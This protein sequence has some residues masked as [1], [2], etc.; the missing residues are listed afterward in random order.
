MKKVRAVLLL[1]IVLIF[2]YWLLPPVFEASN[3]RG[4]D[5]FLVITI[6]NKGLKP[7]EGVVIVGADYKLNNKYLASIT[8]QDFYVGPFGKVDVYVKMNGEVV[9]GVSYLV[10]ISVVGTKLYQ[11][12]FM[13]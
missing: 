13:L 6:V 11:K 12:W 2:I 8:P 9:K 4:Q 1:V 7:V 3:L 10:T 5:T